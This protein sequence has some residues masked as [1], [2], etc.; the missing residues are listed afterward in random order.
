M[1]RIILR[2]LGVVGALACTAALGGCAGAPAPSNAGGVEL[3]PMYG[4]PPGLLRPDGT[5]INGLEPID[6]SA[7]S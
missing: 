1:I 7:V 3:S 4:V 5:M 2:C 6:P